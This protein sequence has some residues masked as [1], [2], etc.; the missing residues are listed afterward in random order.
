MRWFP[1][2][3]KRAARA[4]MVMVHQEPALLFSL[5]LSLRRRFW[6]TISYEGLLLERGVESA[7]VRTLFAFAFD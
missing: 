7:R 6:G 1:W 5:S 4:R 3:L 2:V